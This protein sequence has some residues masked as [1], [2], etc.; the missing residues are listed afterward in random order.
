MTVQESDLVTARTLQMIRAEID[1]RSFQ[2]WAGSR[3]MIG[4]QTFDEGYAM[5]CFLAGVFGELAPQPFR[6]II[7]RSKDNR[8]GVFYGYGRAGVEA[9]R[10]AAAQFADPLQARVLP[11]SSLEGK[12]MPATWKAGTRLGFELLTR[13]TVRRARGHRNPGGEVDAFQREAERYAPGAMPRSREEV[14]IDWLSEQF[15]RRG[16][17]ALDSDSAS[18]A[19]FQRTR[20]MRALR[21]RPFEGPTALLRG[22]ITVTD[23]DDFVRL[24]GRGIGRHRSYGYGM[25]L[26]RPPGKPA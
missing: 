22:T 21:R 14:Y 10:G 13:P 9:L 6:L 15:E 24:L 25:L 5:H 11:G 17:A 4:R 1:L 26:L 12:L 8:R 19:S 16:G 2:H 3:Q 7:P 18:L 20:S 23:G